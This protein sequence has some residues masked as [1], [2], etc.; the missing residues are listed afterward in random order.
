MKQRDVGL[1]PNVSQTSHEGYIYCGETDVTENLV[2]SFVVDANKEGSISRQK[3][4]KQPLD[5]VGRVKGQEFAIDARRRHPQPST[6]PPTEANQS[7]GLSQGVTRS[8]TGT[9]YKKLLKEHNITFFSFGMDEKYTHRYGLRTP[10]LQ[11]V[12]GR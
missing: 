6:V 7:A 5:V 10:W 3:G 2:E 4:R 12:R 9:S 11:C 1:G 8:C